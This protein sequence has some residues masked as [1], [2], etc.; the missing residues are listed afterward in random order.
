MVGELFAP[1]NEKDDNLLFHGKII[2]AE[3]I[4]LMGL[5]QVLCVLL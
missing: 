1:M 5:C 3:P 2:S 4:K